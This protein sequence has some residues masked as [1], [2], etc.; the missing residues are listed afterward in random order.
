MANDIQK[1][2]RKFQIWFRILLTYGF[3]NALVMFFLL[4]SGPHL[5]PR[6]FAVDSEER[7]YL[8]FN[9][10]VYLAEGD[11]FYPVLKGTMQ[12]AMIAI[13][14]KNV[15]Y[16]ADMGDYSA[17]DLNSSK[18]EEGVIVK[19]TI[20]ADQ[21]DRIFVDKRPEREELD[22][23]NGFF[24]RY[25]ETLFDYAVVRESDGG[26]QLLLQMPQSEYMLNMIVKIGFAIVFLSIAVFVVTTKLYESKHP[27]AFARSSDRI[28]NRNDERNNG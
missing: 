3:C 8:S 11:R 19:Q 12:G 25:H 27:E 15:M 16:V 10:G 17:I 5:I 26:E 2:P 6:Y 28:R 20:S 9:N 24:Y 23:Q 18:P 14:D 7:V 22:E 21:A 1:L 4:F 13:S